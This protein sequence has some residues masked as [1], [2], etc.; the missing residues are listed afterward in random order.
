ML[1][2]R[3]ELLTSILRWID[4]VPRKVAPVAFILAQARSEAWPELTKGE[5]LAELE[6]LARDE[7]LLEKSFALSAE[8]STWR[9][10]N[11]GRNYLIEK[12]IVS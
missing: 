7:G 6:A 10:T 1:T 2:N 12:G 8:V 9:I 3:N 5:L 4:A 11:K